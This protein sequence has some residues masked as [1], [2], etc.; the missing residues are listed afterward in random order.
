MLW[1][2]IVLAVYKFM[3]YAT[4]TLIPFT[5]MLIYGLPKNINSLITASLIEH[6]INN[7]ISRH[8]VRMNIPVHYTFQPKYICLKEHIIKN[9]LAIK[10]HCKN[11]KRK[12]LYTYR[13]LTHSELG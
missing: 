13:V 4:K 8:C 11:W 10:P 5:K 6:N 9:M 1:L 3:I 12:I 7:F 2:T